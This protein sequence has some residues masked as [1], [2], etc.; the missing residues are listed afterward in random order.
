[1]NL[2]S[3]WEWFVILCG[4]LLVALT[5]FQPWSWRTQLYVGI[6]LLM[7]FVF[8]LGRRWGRK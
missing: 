6:A 1:M 7:V 5:W 4:V 3:L 2:R 8:D